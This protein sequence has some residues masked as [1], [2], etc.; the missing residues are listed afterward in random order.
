MF[1]PAAALIAF[2]LAAALYV[3]SFFGA[4]DTSLALRA[5]VAF[6]VGAYGSLAAAWI[7]RQVRS[8]ALTGLAPAGL[9]ILLL[10]IIFRIFIAAADPR[11]VTAQIAAY[12]FGACAVALIANL[13]GASADLVTATNVF[14]CVAAANVAAMVLGISFFAAFGPVGLAFPLAA[15]GFGWIASVVALLAFR[16]PGR[17]SEGLAGVLGIAALYGA[18]RLCLDGDWMLFFATVAGLVAAFGL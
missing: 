7:S 13:A 9:A 18:A 8:R 3:A 17:W 11:A 2:V 6:V 16:E 1:F 4:H 15:S 5:L 12:A 10:G 14:A